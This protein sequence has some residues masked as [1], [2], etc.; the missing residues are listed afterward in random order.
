M[1]EQDMAK[2][3]GEPILEERRGRTRSPKRG[4]VQVWEDIA[5]CLSLARAGITGTLSVFG[6]ATEGFMYSS[7]PA[8]Q[9][10]AARLAHTSKVGRAVADGLKS[11]CIRGDS[12][13]CVLSTPFA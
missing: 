6:D 3:V 2:A 10:S 4:T 12:T 7:H 13:N 1:G 5:Q 11:D 8:T 9:A